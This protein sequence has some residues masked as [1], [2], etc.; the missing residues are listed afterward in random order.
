[1]NDT[2]DEFRDW[3]AAYVLGALSVDDRAAYEQHLLHCAACA[4][5][6]TE[7]A[8]M[9]GI[10]RK[11]T[12][13]EAE[14][15]MTVPADGHLRGHEH[16]P[17]LV[18]R[19]AAQANRRRRRV[20]AGGLALMIGAAAILALG[21]IAVGAGLHP[22]PDAAHAPVSSAP[23]GT[24]LAMTPL[25]PG[26]MTATLTVRAMPWGTRFDWSCDYLNRDGQ[27]NWAKSYALV[28]TDSTGAETTVATWSATQE[29]RAA[30]LASSSKLA[31]STIR[32]VEIRAVGS[33]AALVAVNL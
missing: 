8:G 14:A 27:L 30:E 4:A 13:A 25:Q 1:M 24:T 32:R 22:S 20:R 7:L 17:G 16:E 31:T 10:L 26:T 5:A 11:L 3:D 23:A 18:Q 29:P 6:V 19:L 15:L 28:A 12:A 21:G 9:P 2:P 33:N